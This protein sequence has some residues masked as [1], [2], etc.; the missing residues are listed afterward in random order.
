[1][2]ERWNEVLFNKELA[3][4]IASLSPE[5]VRCILLNEGYDFSEDEII[6]TAK[7]LNEIMLIYS[8]DNYTEEQYIQ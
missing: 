2:D 7:E 3:E 1:M 4:I 8:G 5:R 6:A